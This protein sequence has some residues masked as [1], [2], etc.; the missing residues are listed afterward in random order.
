MEADANLI[1]DFRDGALGLRVN[2]RSIMQYTVLLLLIIGC[3]V[4]AFVFSNDMRD[5]QGVEA[6]QL[7]AFEALV[8][9]TACYNWDR[10]AG[11]IA[12]F[13]RS[14][15]MILSRAGLAAILAFGI[16]QWWAIANYSEA[17]A[18]AMH[19]SQPVVLAQIAYV[20][21]LFALPFRVTRARLAHLGG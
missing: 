12:A 20:V 4:A 9:L 3:L 15:V 21:L 18:Q 11:A 6:W 16:D 8:Y 17:F 13:A 10:R 1:D 5:L 7:A 19:A 14:A 2:P